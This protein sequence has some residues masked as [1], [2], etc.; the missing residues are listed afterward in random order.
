MFMIAF[1]ETGI[2]FWL[3]YYMIGGMVIIACTKVSLLE[4][5]NRSSITRVVIC[6]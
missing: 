5:T 4:L 6:L 3:L 2:A 1:T